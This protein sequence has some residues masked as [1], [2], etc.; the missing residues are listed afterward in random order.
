M[1][2]HQKFK[3]ALLN[4]GV[5][6]DVY[7]GD[8]GIEYVRWKGADNEAVEQVQASLFGAPLPSGRNISFDDKTQEQFKL[9]L[10]ENE[11]PFTT[12]TRDGKEFIA[13]EAADTQKVEG[14]KYFP[15]LAPEP[16]QS[17]RDFPVKS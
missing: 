6:H 5:P 12:H 11:V 9:W 15:K 4:A 10:A 17:V 13:W 14:W 2:K 1:R 16:N 7:V 8:Y 3:H